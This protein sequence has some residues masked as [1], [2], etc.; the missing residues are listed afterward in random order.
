MTGLQVVYRVES[1]VQASR[2]EARSVID[3]PIAGGKS[4]LNFYLGRQR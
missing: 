3:A 2:A 4:E 1:A